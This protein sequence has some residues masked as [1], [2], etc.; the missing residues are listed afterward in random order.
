VTA[1][2]ALTLLLVVAAIIHL[3]LTPEHLGISTLLGI[4]FL[5]AGVAQLALAGLVLRWPQRTDLVMG[6]IVIVNIALI[7]MYVYAVLVGLPL[8]AGHAADDG[9]GLRIGSGEPVD[10]KGAIDLTVEIAAVALAVVIGFGR[11]GN[12]TSERA[13]SPLG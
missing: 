8:E 7:V 5:L 11:A 12:R 4:G 6:A 13:P 9:G 10:L 2:L 1:R 3:I